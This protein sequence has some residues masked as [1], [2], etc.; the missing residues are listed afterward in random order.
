MG[1]YFARRS[2]VRR[3]C[4]AARWLA[5]LIFW[6]PRSSAG[7]VPPAPC[8]GQSPL[9]AQRRQPLFLGPA[10]LGV[11]IGPPCAL[12]PPP[13]PH[14]HGGALLGLLAGFLA[15][16]KRGA[17]ALDL[18]WAALACFS[19]ALRR[20]PRLRGSRFRAP[21]RPA[22][23]ARFIQRVSGRSPES[24]ATGAQRPSGRKS[25]LCRQAHI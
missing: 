5:L 21:G 14:P 22:P 19:S 6:P 9:L 15:G 8:H 20:R 17:Q 16:F 11:R 23:R 3:A 12:R 1:G 2:R 4:R 24:A 18:G 7:F 13:G 10:R 25:G